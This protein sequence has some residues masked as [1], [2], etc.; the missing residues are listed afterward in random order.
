MKDNALQ[1][2]NIPIAAIV[3][4]FDPI[5]VIENK[6]YINY[7]IFNQIK[8]PFNFYP[9]EHNKL[10]RECFEEIQPILDEYRTYYEFNLFP[11]IAEKLKIDNNHLYE[12]LIEK[13]KNDVLLNNIVIDDHIINEYN[14]INRIKNKNFK[15][16]MLI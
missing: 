8:N 11:D 3:D 16:L 12:L 1:K 2:L 13:Q 5:P 14:S 15:D 9:K 6:D 4:N 7:L 10:I